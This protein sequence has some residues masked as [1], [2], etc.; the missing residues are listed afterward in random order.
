MARRFASD[1]FRLHVNG[2]GFGL[3]SL[4]QNSSNGVGRQ[5]Q[6]GPLIADL[7][8]DYIAWRAKWCLPKQRQRRN[9]E[10]AAAVAAAAADLKGP[11]ADRPSKRPSQPS[12]M[13]SAAAKA[14]ASDSCSGS[15]LAPFEYEPLNDPSCI[16]ILTLEPGSGSDPLVGRLTVESLASSPAPYETISYVWGTGGRCSELACDGAAIPLTQSIHDALARVRHPRGPEEDRA[17]SRQRRLWADQIC[18][19]QAD[20]AERSQQVRL[21][22]AV[23]KNASRTLVWLGRDDDG[24]AADAVT[25]V[26]YLHG[27]FNDEEAH[28]EFRTAHTT[29]LAKQSKEPWI[30]I[31]H[32]TK[33]PWVS[34][35]ISMTL[36]NG[37]KTIYQIQPF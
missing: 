29:D 15:G 22:N 3:L 4:V 17:P 35:Y 25:M 1:R 7:H 20:I 37:V 28:A 33:L 13:A 32:L 19:N 8:T 24:V 10:V 11:K 36:L 5:Q 14:E 12:V 2:R 9:Q 21:M 30:P 18:I 23:Y 6:L 34:F 16:R 26:Q 27:V 31:S